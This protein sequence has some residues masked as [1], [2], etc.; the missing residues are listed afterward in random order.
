M[1]TALVTCSSPV[2]GGTMFA[3]IEAWRAIGIALSA[4]FS[5]T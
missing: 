4:H 1:T 3:T 5:G 2:A